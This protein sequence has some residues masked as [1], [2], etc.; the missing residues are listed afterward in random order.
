MR[1]KNRMAPIHFIKKNTDGS[2]VA[3][4]PRH[5]LAFNCSESDMIK[6]GNNEIDTLSPDTFNV[7]AKYGVIRNKATIKSRN[8]ASV[9]IPVITFLMTTNCNLKCIYCYANS[10]TLKTLTLADASK[11][12]DHIID[13][14]IK[15]GKTAIKFKFHGAGEPT[16][17]F[18]QLA[19]IVKYSTK[20]AKLAGIRPFYSLTTNAFADIST[21]QW[22]TN[23]FNSITV[24]FDM[25]PNIHDK[26]RPTL[27]A[28]GS[29]ECVLN[30]I[31]HIG[32]SSA[33]LGIRSTV[34]RMGTKSMADSVKLL[35]GYNVSSVCFEPVSL[36]G[37]AENQD[38]SVNVSD[39]V[40]GYVEAKKVSKILNIPI[41]YSGITAH[42][43]R[44]VHCGAYGTN[45][46]V[47]PEGQISL[48]YEVFDK[49][50]PLFSSFVTDL[51]SSMES[52]S[53][54]CKINYR[55]HGCFALDNCGGGCLSRHMSKSEN[56][57]RALDE[58]CSITRE[59]LRD[60]VVS[61]LE[62]SFSEYVLFN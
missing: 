22:V 38:I 14:A 5:F 58:K 20:Q 17:A 44:E 15:I 47:T 3:Y 45:F 12:I 27:D 10:G 52:V 40:S 50:H 18:K 8:I 19:E 25:N 43:L 24:S 33:Y 32:K 51:S 2:F 56:A 26:H 28:G 37:S 35:A 16:L 36:V 34:T 21:I 30:N 61:T 31:R 4:A 57:I 62:S 48:C 9:G 46:V 54:P 39:F 60:E 6:I 55:C 42:K 53:N 41:T 13:R 29:A 11:P 7:L 49:S 1:Y 23:H 59:I